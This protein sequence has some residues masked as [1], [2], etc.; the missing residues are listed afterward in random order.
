[1]I[2]GKFPILLTYK[3]PATALGFGQKVKIWYTI[4]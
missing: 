3:N 4:Q 1:V 2:G